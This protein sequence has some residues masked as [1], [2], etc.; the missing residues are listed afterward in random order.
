MKDDEAID[1]AGEQRTD[2][3]KIVRNLIGTPDD[4]LLTSLSAQDEIKLFI[5]QGTTKRRQIL[6]RFLDLDV[7]DKMYDLAK[8][9]LNTI[10]SALKMYPDKDWDS[11]SKNFEI[12][13]NPKDIDFTKI[14]LKREVRT[15]K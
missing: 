15:K 11:L 3:E 9:E 2:T 12:P 6:A 7:F 1:L 14:K 5:T 13:K 8:N 10:K 4:F